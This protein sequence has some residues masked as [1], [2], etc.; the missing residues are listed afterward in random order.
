MSTIKGVFKGNKWLKWVII[1]VLV[2]LAYFLSAKIYSLFTN[3][4]SAIGLGQTQDQQ[5][6]STATVQMAQSLIQGETLPHDDSFYQAIADGQR[7]RM[8]GIYFT[9]PY[10]DLAKPLTGLTDVEL[11]K[12]YG[13][14]GL[15]SDKSLFGISTFTGTLFDY[16]KANLSSFSLFG[17]SDLDKMRTIWQNTNL[18]KF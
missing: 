7:A 1:A 18:P 2:V 3:I 8:N 11:I 4:F 15:S 12:I 14:F 17:T 16:Y 9:N 6:Q 10:D 13:D 5:Q